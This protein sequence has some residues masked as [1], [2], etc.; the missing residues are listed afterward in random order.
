[1]RIL[2]YSKYSGDNFDS[3]K[4]GVF[5]NKCIKQD[6]LIIRKRSVKFKIFI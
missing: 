4:N 1:M 5:L 6:S 3:C 2:N